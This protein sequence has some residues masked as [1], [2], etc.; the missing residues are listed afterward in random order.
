MFIHIIRYVYINTFQVYQLNPTEKMVNSQPFGSMKE[1]PVFQASLQFGIPC[2]V[3]RCMS[4]RFGRMSMET[5]VLLKMWGTLPE[6]QKSW[7]FAQKPGFPWND[8]ISFQ[9]SQWVC[10]EPF[11]N[12]KNAGCIDRHPTRIDAPKKSLINLKKMDEN[13]RRDSF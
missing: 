4:F 3:G 13:G 12:P 11:A 7:I 8:K 5:L 10:W 2:I 9:L 1:F 6:P